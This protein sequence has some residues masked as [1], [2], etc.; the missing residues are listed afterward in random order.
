MLWDIIGN[1]RDSLGM[2]WAWEP[3]E[4]QVVLDKNSSVR[5]N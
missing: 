4:K 2:E 3:S 5:R 1:H